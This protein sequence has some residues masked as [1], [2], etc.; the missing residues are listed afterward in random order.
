MRNFMLA[1]PV[2]LSAAF[3]TC[4]SK[5]NI[6]THTPDAIMS[7]ELKKKGDIQVRG[8]YTN[9]GTTIGDDMPL[10]KITGADVQA[11][12]A[13]T[14]RVGIQAY[15]AFRKEQNGYPP[16]TGSGTRHKHTYTRNGGGG[17]IV[18]FTP[19]NAKAS[20][21]FS[22][23]AGLG[24]AQYSANIYKETNGGPTHFFNNQVNKAFLSGNL[25]QQLGVFSYGIGVRYSSIGYSHFAT[26]YSALQLETEGLNKLYHNRANFLDGHIRLGATFPQLPWLT[27]EGQ[28]TA[29]GDMSSTVRYSNGYILSGGVRLN[30]DKLGGKGK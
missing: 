28:I 7:F 6:I 1:L 23:S 8:S 29:G 11:A 5:P 24:T 13:I 21:F 22:G 4:E 14:N 27:F 19:L 9:H 16:E 20:L 2:A 30:L 17:A 12:V 10:N 25:Y 26:N 3:E 18:Y 15:G